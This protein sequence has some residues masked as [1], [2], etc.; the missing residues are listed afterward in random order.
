[1]NKYAPNLSPSPWTL[2]RNRFTEMRKALKLICFD[3]NL[4][5]PKTRR[6]QG[7]PSWAPSN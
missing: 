7:V 2:L 1:M 3:S 5:I 4:K 6:E